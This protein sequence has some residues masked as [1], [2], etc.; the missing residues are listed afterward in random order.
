MASEVH[1]LDQE[2]GNGTYH[3][4]ILVPSVA[5][6]AIIGKG[7]ETIEQL[8]R[9]AGAKVKMSKATD[10]YPGTTERVCLITGSIEGIQRVHEFIMEK[11][12]EK[13]DPNAKIAIDFDHRQP[14]E[15]EKQV[16]ILVPNSTAGMI[17]GKGGSY[18]QQIKEESG[19]YV[20]ISQ[21]STEHAL[22]ERCITVIGEIDSNK[23]ACNMI[24]SKIVADPQSGSCL[25]IS[26][27]DVT[28][29]V[30]NFNPTGSPFAN[31]RSV[32][33]GSIS[34]NNTNFS[35]NSSLNSLSPSV[36][37]S[38]HSPRPSATFTESVPYLGMGI[39]NPAIP[40]TNVIQAIEMIRNLLRSNGYS[41]QAVSEISA[42]L[43]TLASYRILAIGGIN[44]IPI[45]STLGMGINSSPAAGNTISQC[46]ISNQ[47]MYAS[48][49]V[50]AGASM[51]GPIGSPGSGMSVLGSDC[52]SPTA[53]R[54]SDH[55]LAKTEAAMFES[56]RRPSPD[57]ASPSA[58]ALPMNN[59]SF[60]LETCLMAGSV[61]SK[62]NSMISDQQ[63]IDAT[64]IQIEV[65]ENLVGAIL[66]P[67]GKD[68]VEI[69]RFS[70]ANIQ[71]SKKGIFAP[72]TR[73][74]IVTITG[75]PE[76]VNTAQYLIERQLSD[77]EAKRA[78]QNA[79]EALR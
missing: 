35:V 39:G 9:D 25:N 29:P 3:F 14:A 6:G 46:A 52:T 37:N 63:I 76:A 24:L 54:S 43:N 23:K 72:G 33:S 4:K 58:A 7:G 12:H 70:G 34:D 67:G 40:P 15:R 44:G 1:Y 74:R 2:Q 59:N 69:H 75:T 47:G 38:F 28:G 50:G 51:F 48:E 68:L 57:L 71:I 32:S 61:V 21:K 77:E 65:G 8:Q 55:F 30:A 64:K 18:I 42:A 45:I 60:G 5:A 13:P 79:M 78:Q 26:Y 20:Q 56:F 27:A 62:K 31:P 22:V 16:K 36:T 66:G 53:S 41:E 10:F 17:I 73:N 11:I 19:S 49:P